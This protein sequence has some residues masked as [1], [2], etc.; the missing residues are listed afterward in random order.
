MRDEQDIL[1]GAHCSDLD[2]LVALPLS[3]CTHLGQRRLVSG[4]GR[5]NMLD[6][7]FESQTGEEEDK[8]LPRD[9]IS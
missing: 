6:L 7:N 4:G 5:E 2:V 1:I 9:R 3:E 8:V